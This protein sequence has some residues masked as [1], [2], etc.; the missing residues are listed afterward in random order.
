MCFHCCP[1]SR[2]GATGGLFTAWVE[3]LL[4]G[5]Q[6]ADFT[7]TLPDRCLLAGRV[8]WFYLGK[9]VWPADL[10]FIYPRWTID[11]TVWW[12]YLFPAGVLALAAGLWRLAR[13]NRGP[14]AGFLFFAGTLFPALGFFNVYPFVFSYVADHFQYLASLGVL[15]PAAAGLAHAAG[16]LQASRAAAGRWSARVAGGLLLATLSTLTWRQCGVYRDARTLYTDTLARNPGCAMAHTGLGD[17]LAK[18]P[19]RLPDAIAHFEAAIRLNPRDAQAHN[20]LGYALAK[21]PGRLPEAVAEYEAA[22]RII[23]EFAWAHNNLGVTLEKIPG[24]LP[25]AIAHFEEAADLDPD[26]ADFQDNLGVALTRVPGRTAEVIAHFEAAVHLNPRSAAM[27]NN[28]AIALAA[29]PGRLAEATAHF[30]VAALLNP[31]SAEMQANLGAVLVNTPGR[32]PDAIAHFEAAVRLDP[33]SAKAHDNLGNALALVPGKLPEA[34]QQLE[35]AVRLD[36][37]SAKAQDDLGKLLL[38][39]PDRLAEAIGHFELALRSDPNS[40]EIHDDLGV[41]LLQTP[42]RSPE[43]IQHLEAAL[44]IDPELVRGALCAGNRVVHPSR[45]QSGGPGADG[46]GLENQ[47]RFPT[48]P[49]MDGPTACLPAIDRRAANPRCLIR[50][51]GD[52]PGILKKTSMPPPLPPPPARP[53]PVVLAAAVLIA[54]ALAAYHNSFSGPFVFDD[55][56]GIVDNRTIRHGFPFLSSL[57]PP[58]NVTV[59]G[60]PIANFTFALNHAI[61]GDNVWSYHALNLLIHVLAGLTLFGVLR[62]TLLLPADGGRPGVSPRLRELATPAALAVALLWIVHPLQ[63]EAVTY[64]FHL[65]RVFKLH[66][67]VQDEAAVV[68]YDRPQLRLCHPYSWI[69]FLELLHHHGRR[70]RENLQLHLPFQ[71]AVFHLTFIHYD[72]KFLRVVADDFFPCQCP[73]TALKERCF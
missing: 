22:L 71:H 61:S 20:N 58:A 40:A 47:S 18:E 72:D 26:S 14:L 62:R 37:G 60:R 64:T 35:T 38:R 24:R 70:K 1:G 27:Q 23:P 5:A 31:G 8:V 49:G 10:I 2:L 34:I 19:G 59:S 69:V 29:V 50:P 52:F 25:E 56:P 36:P 73:S 66:V 17:I 7:L 12:Q 28:L 51:D 32:L 16:R 13:R 41:A 63:T 65:F 54:A 15:V 4:I 6:G 3:R 45:P 43:A 46:G 67:A 11:A 53:W 55:I 21:D 48:G 30:E 9:V 39:V 57:V 68:A 44:R 33:G 42:G